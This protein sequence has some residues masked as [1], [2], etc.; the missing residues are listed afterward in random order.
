MSTFER[1]IGKVSEF[2]AVPSNPT[3]GQEF[4]DT[5][6]DYWMRYSGGVWRGLAMT[7]TS[8]STST[9]STSSSTTSTSSSTTV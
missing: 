2:S 9:T 1:L 7:S 5:D 6:T 3:E 8:S 4:Y